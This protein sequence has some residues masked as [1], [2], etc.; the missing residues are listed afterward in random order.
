MTSTDKD[1]IALFRELLAET[2]QVLKA[3]Q[4]DSESTPRELG[5][6]SLSFL[7]LLMLVDERTGVEITTDDVSLDTSF[8]ELASLIDRKAA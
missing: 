4:F 1:Y 8:S 5:I 7:E 6:D 3:D 2:G